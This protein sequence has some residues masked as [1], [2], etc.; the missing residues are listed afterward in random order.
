M[1]GIPQPN[2]YASYYADYVNRA[3][4]E[5]DIVAAL[6]EQLEIS[7]A[8]MSKVSE[9]AS[10]ERREG[11]WSLREVVGHLCDAERVFHTVRSGFPEV[12]SMSWPA[13]TRTSM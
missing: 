4:M 11:K 10:K 3:A 12:T 1:T 6:E 2:E 9:D 13:S 5:Q 7:L 8:T